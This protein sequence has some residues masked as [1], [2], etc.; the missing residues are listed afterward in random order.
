MSMPEVVLQELDL[1]KPS[2][3]SFSPSANPNLKLWASLGAQIL[4]RVQNAEIQQF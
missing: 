3:T 2:E 1:V 4:G